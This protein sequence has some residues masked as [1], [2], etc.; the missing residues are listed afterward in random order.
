MET[1]NG[2][3]QITYKHSAPRCNCS[4]AC[5]VQILN[6]EN[7]YFLDSRLKTNKKPSRIKILARISTSEKMQ[8]GFFFLYHP[9][10]SRRVVNV[11]TMR[12]LSTSHVSIKT[13]TCTCP[14]PVQSYNQWTPLNP[15][16]FHYHSDL[17]ST[18]AGNQLRYFL[19]IKTQSCILR[20]LIYSTG[21]IVFSLSYL[22]LHINAAPRHQS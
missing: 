11:V 7:N 5:F 4:T 10:P 1:T 9:N 16:L 2:I 3:F 6:L 21:Y 20:R 15:Y 17:H 22:Y 14:V 13:C 18:S 8:L 12:R 19:K